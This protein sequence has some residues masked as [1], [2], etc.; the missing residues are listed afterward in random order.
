MPQEVEETK[1]EIVPINEVPPAKPDHVINGLEAWFVNN[2]K[3]SN[4]SL[5]TLRSIEIAFE[6]RGLPQGQKAWIIESTDRCQLVRE[7]RDGEWEWLGE[8]P[9]VRDALQ[10]L[11]KKLG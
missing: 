6:V 7:V 11:S 9:G 2:G 5:G 8:F 3:I 1:V 4:G 10:A